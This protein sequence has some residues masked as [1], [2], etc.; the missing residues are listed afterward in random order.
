MDDL[1]NCYNVPRATRNLEQRW[2]LLYRFYRQPRPHISIEVNIP[3]RCKLFQNT[4]KI[5]EFKFEY[6]ME[7]RRKVMYNDIRANMQDWFNNRR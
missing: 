5:K 7:T 1:R 6:K 3:T 4:G 2:S